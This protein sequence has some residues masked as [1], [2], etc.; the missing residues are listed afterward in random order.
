MSKSSKRKRLILFRHAKSSWSEGVEDHDRPLSDR[1]RKA[2]P[3]IGH[4]LAKAKLQPDLVIVS[5]A[6]R[7]Q[8]TWARAVRAMKGPI[9]TQNSREIYLASAEK[10]LEVIHGV[11]TSVGTLMLVGHNPGLEDLARLL[12]KELG[13]EPGARLR[14]KFPTAGIAVLSFEVGSWA[15]VAAESGALDRFVTPKTIG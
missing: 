6:R 11:D 14:E 15:D 9:E 7:A 13:G 10:L 5:T 3:V 2:A 12:M 1:G 4:Y 8:E